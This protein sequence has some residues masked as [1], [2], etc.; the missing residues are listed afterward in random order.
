M[1]EFDS[2]TSMCGEIQL[3]KLFD[4]CPPTDP[5]APY[6][7]R[8]RDW[9]TAYLAAPHP[10]LGREGPVCPFTAASISRE[11]FWVGCVD[12]SDLTAEA[13]EN[14][15]SEMIA[16]FRRI[17]PADGPDTLLKTVLILF[18][19]VTDY[20]LIDEAQKKLKQKSIPIGL[21]I[22][23]F[24]PECEEP[25]IWNPEFRPLQ[26]PLP[27]LAIRNMVSSDFPFLAT[28]TKWL[29][30]YFKRFAPA[31]PASIRSMITERLDSENR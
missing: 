22:G 21:M 23:Q 14:A 12:K 2:G 11:T 26:S 25:G 29:D 24:Y 17:S 7:T 30:E 15:V 31:I 13:I 5:L 9:A 3:T 28:K 4:E 8:I 6:I 1:G 20:G 19:S 10:E 18:P 16:G 27:L